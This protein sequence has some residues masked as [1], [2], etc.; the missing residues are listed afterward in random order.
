MKSLVWVLLAAACGGDGG[1]CGDGQ[2]GGG[3]A[4][5]DGN[6]TA[7]DG[8]ERDCT[9]SCQ[10]AA[11]CDDG[12]ACTLDACGA[13]H[14]C[15][16][17]PASGATCEADA[18]PATPDVCVAGAC[19]ASIC[20]DEVVDARRETCDDGNDLDGDGCEHDCRGTPTAFRVVTV[21]FADPHTWTLGLGGCEDNGANFDAELQA[22]V[23]NYALNIVLVF[24]PLDPA[25]ESTP[26]DIVFGPDCMA[27]G[28]GQACRLAS[29]AVTP[30][31]VHGQSSGTCFEPDPTTLNPDY[32][33]P[34]SSSAAPCFVSDPQDL[35]VPIGPAVVPFSDAIATATY[36]GTPPTMLVSGVFAGF[37]SEA[38]TKTVE[39]YPGIP[40]YSFLA[41]GQA[42]GSS[43]SSE[44]DRDTHLTTRGFWFYLELTAAPVAWT[45]P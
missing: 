42:Q 33:P 25:A 36:S 22:D 16:H 7:G 14:A 31:V 4:C 17:A 29:G 11:D 34:P 43:C 21:R 45:E 41:A 6:G 38:D 3:E 28:S 2:V 9:F 40:L 35:A 15:A 13:D 18:D 10:G 30:L 5:D 1:R 32:A 44:D 8:C 20:G 37:V 12:D 26:V 27:S 39:P 24:R 19:A 23:D